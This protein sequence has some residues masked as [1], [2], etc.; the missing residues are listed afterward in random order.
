MID[1]LTGNSGAG[2]TTFAMQMIK[3]RSDNRPILLD[4]DDLRERLQIGYSLT[5][6][7]R[8]E[9]NLRT[10][11]LAKLLDDQGFDVIVAVICPYEDLRRQVQKICGCRFVYLEYDGDDQL[12]DKPYEKPIDPYM[13]ITLKAHEA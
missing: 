12:P 8:I 2:K 7:D 5:R 9:H 1:W 3:Q 10:A 13:R 11:R 4:G 6:E